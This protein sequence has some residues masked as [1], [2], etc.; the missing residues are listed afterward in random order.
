MSERKHVGGCMCG[1]VRYEATGEE[2]VLYCHCNSCRRATGAVVATFVAFAPEQVMFTKGQRKFYESSPGVKRAF[3]GDCGTPLTWEGVWNGEGVTE[4]YIST[5]DDP[6][7]YSPRYHEFYSEKIP[8]F[9]ISDDL[10][11]HENAA[12]D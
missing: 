7:G 4:F 11:R 9:E 3:C 6:A 5:L 2:F 10:P 12:Q 8:W 1:A